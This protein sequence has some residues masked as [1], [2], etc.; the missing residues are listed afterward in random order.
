[1]PLFVVKD[2]CK[3]LEYADLTTVIRRHCRRAQKPQSLIALVAMNRR[4][5]LYAGGTRLRALTRRCRVGNSAAR[6][7]ISHQCTEN[8]HRKPEKTEK[9]CL[10]AVEKRH[11]LP[12]INLLTARSLCRQCAR[13]LEK[14]GEQRDFLIWLKE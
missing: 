9:I 3:Q 2:V 1:M 13:A 14:A 12:L 8:G 6:R 7:L 11:D 10:V 5:K 4:W